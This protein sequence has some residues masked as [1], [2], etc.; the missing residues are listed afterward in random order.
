MC[1]IET[2]I[3]IKASPERVWS[4]L[5]SFNEYPDWNPFIRFVERDKESVNHLHVSIQVPGYKS[6]SLRPEIVKYLQNREL[7]WKGKLLIKGIFDGELFN[8]ILPP[9]MNK[10][11]KKTE[12]G[13]H[14]MN[15]AFKKQ[16]EL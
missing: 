14:Q 7:R 8:G 9:L 1:K 12:E 16:C 15:I 6:M 3:E 5:T 10:L 11:L 13:F 4:Q 2:S